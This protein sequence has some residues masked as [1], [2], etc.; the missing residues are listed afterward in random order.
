[1]CGVYLLA[2]AEFSLV[3][4]SSLPY[5]HVFSHSHSHSHPHSSIFILFSI[6][7]WQ[8]PAEIT[9]NFPPSFTDK[10][11][12]V[13]KA[14]LG[15]AH[16]IVLCERFVSPRLTNPWGVETQ[17]Y[18]WGFGRH[19]QLG[20]DLVTDLPTPQIV[21]MPK[22][23][24]VV[25]ISAGKSHSCAVT[26]YG[27]V[28]SWGKGWFGVLGQGDDTLKIAPCLLE[29]TKNMILKVSCGQMHTTAL[30]LRRGGMSRR[31]VEKTA[32][33]RTMC[34]IPPV[35][36]GLPKASASA[37]SL[38]NNARCLKQDQT[39]GKEE[40]IPQLPAAAPVPDPPP[41]A[42]LPSDTGEGKVVFGADPKGRSERAAW[43]EA[44]TTPTV[45]MQEEK[46]SASPPQTPPSQPRAFDERKQMT[47][48]ESE[49][50]SPSSASNRIGKE[51][52]WRDL[53]PSEWY[54]PSRKL[55]VRERIK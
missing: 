10:G 3:S 27:Q 29:T 9:D 45:N 40:I 38:W 23:E 16:T 24:R 26:V 46:K 22:W 14:A 5:K 36:L 47:N 54:K 44:V 1:M 28:Y 55:Q 33:E 4:G 32:V 43:K 49:L 42:V 6:R 12:R 2:C 15:G 41:L 39:I 37:V 30:S 31:A 52:T 48:L 34:G 13:V 17:L 20:T 50:A 25:N 53:T 18:A 8:C 11:F 7:D 51:R 35:Y 21:K 19:G